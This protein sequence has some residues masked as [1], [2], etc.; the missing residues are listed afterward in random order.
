MRKEDFRASCALLVIKALMEQK[1][2]VGFVVEVERIGLVD[3]FRLL[4][5]IPI[6]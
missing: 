2:D 3:F 4:I 1:R 6:W 5:I